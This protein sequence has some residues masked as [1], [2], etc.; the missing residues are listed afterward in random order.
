MSS[1]EAAGG[2]HAPAGDELLPHKGEDEFVRTQDEV[3]PFHLVSQEE[4]VV[5]TQDGSMGRMAGT[6]SKIIELE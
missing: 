5:D 1:T 2:L 3:A 4:K 6:T